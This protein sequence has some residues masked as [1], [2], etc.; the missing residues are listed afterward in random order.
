VLAFR[1][2]ASG[3]VIDAAQQLVRSFRLRSGGF[4]ISAFGF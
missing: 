1:P 4:D 2:G 3:E